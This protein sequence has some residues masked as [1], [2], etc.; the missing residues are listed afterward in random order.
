MV[1]APFRLRLKTNPSK[2]G[3]RNGLPLHFFKIHYSNDPMI[4]IFQFYPLATDGKKRVIWGNIMRMAIAMMSRMTKGML[5][6]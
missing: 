4:P 3:D 2:S 6:L 5:A 1:A